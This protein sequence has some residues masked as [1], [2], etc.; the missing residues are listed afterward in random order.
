M[1][2]AE[3]VAA[4]AQDTGMRKDDTEIFINSLM[5]TIIH[6]VSHGEKITLVGFGTFLVANR[7]ARIGHNPKTGE[8]I[9]IPAKK[10]AYFKPGLEFAEA[11]NTKKAF[12][13][14]PIERG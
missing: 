12:K 6:Q 13:R 9:N 3:L 1:N 14:H 2:K 11:V 10:I 4:V 8:P 5:N 7:I